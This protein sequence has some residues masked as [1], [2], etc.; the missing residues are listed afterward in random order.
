MNRIKVFFIVPTLYGGGAERI[1]SYI[2]QYIDKD[3]FDVSLIIIGFEKDST[4]NVSGVPITFLNKTRV[5]KA[6]LAL[7]KLFKKEK[8]QVVLSTLTHLNSLMGFMSIVF[9]KIKFIGRHCIVSRAA[10]KYIDRSD[11]LTSKIARL[12]TK[13]GY[14]FL[15]IILCQS[16]DMRND[17]LINNF[18]VPKHKLRVINNPI[19]DNF[20]LKSLDGTHNRPLRL[21]TVSR[22]V[23]VK[24]HSRLLNMLSK[25]KIPF[26][27]SI[28]GD[29]SERENIFKQVADLGLKDKVEHVPFTNE[30][31]KYLSKSDYYI[32]GSY[33]EG[34]PNCLL[35]SCSVGTPVIAFEAPGGL[36]EIIENGVNGF[37]VSNENEFIQKLNVEKQWDPR[38]VRESVYKKFNKHKIAR[39]Y[40]K[41]FSE[42]V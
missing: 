31:A 39:D 30:V 41:L 13:L 19:R 9:P 11:S 2:P 36:N 24:G 4:F 35:E 40:E 21:I 17:M 34:F 22:L 25:L 10:N 7:I 37:L 5:L 32:M 42:L 23:K 26:H 1:T 15:D 3:K 12:R 8:P 20:D 6:P 38:I 27:Y 14:K 29:G 33:A 18:K 28:V 16:V